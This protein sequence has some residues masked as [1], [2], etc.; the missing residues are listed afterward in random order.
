MA[1]A[2][3]AFLA[4]VAAGI[5]GLLIY[6]VVRGPAKAARL[7]CQASLWIRNATAQPLAEQPACG[8]ET[9]C[10]E[11]KQCPPE[12]ADLCPA[13]KNKSDPCW[14]ACMRKSGKIKGQC[15]SCIRFSMTE[16]VRRARM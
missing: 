6:A 1:L 4:L 5:A 9:S 11:Y 16:Y 8:G 15:M 14:M 2:A 7:P 13:Y 3:V 12:K 10:W